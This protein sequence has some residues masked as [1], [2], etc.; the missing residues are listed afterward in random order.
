MNGAVPGSRAA[1]IPAFQAAPWIAAVVEG[2]SAVLELVVVVDDG[3][4]DGTGELARGA[5]ARVFT[6]PRNRGK[7]WALGTGFRELLAAG[8]SEIVT[9]DADGQHLPGEIPRLVEARRRTSADLVIGTRS[10]LFGAMSR[11]RR[12]SNR[13]SSWAISIL[14]GAAQSDIQSG[15]RLYTRRLVEELGLPRGRFE[16]ESA[17]VVRAVRT[18]LQ[19]VG[20]PVELAYADGRGA[21]HYRPVVDSLR[22]AKAVV[23]ARWGGR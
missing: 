16:F 23:E 15:F 14:A 2:T 22:I 10:H 5:G 6:H 7:G 20:V 12:T 13:L 3:S 18:G 9:L 17:I 19:V 8:V 11:L 1:L 21:S 4:D